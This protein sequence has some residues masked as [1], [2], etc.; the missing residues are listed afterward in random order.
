MGGDGIPTKDVWAALRR[1]WVE[2][3]ITEKRGTSAPFGAV[4]NPEKEH[5]QEVRF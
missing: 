2:A 1:V 3:G 4:A 5:L